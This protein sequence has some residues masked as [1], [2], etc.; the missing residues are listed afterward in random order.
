M[1]RP[2]ATKMGRPCN[3][4]GQVCMDSY[5]SVRPCGR[6]GQGHRLRVPNGFR[7]TKVSLWTQDRDEPEGALSAMAG[8]LAANDNALDRTI[9][10]AKVPQD[11]CRGPQG[12]RSVLCAD[13][14]YHD[15]AVRQRSPRQCFAPAAAFLP[16]V[17]RR[18]ARCPAGLFPAGPFA[19]LP[20]PA[21]FFPAGAGAVADTD[22]A[23]GMAAGT[24]TGR[25][26]AAGR[27]LTSTSSPAPRSSTA[28]SSPRYS[29]C[30]V[31]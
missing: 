11:F 1:G 5:V 13:G 18:T 12:M 3:A 29:S 14:S 2:T 22:P 21:A 31:R 24:G 8:L 7:H 6:A 27:E 17:L 26:P 23:D 4:T 28:S 15:G 25:R 20:L 30:D 16:E 9:M 19:A 10:E